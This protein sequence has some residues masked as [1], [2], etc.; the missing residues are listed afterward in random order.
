MKTFTWCF[1]GQEKLSSYGESTGKTIDGKGY[2]KI[3]GVRP[4]TSPY[5]V[6]CHTGKFEAGVHA[7]YTPV[8]RPHMPKLDEFIKEWKAFVNLKVKRNKDGE[9]L[10]CPEEYCGICRIDRE[11][12]FT[13]AKKKSIRLGIFFHSPIVIICNDFSYTDVLGLLEEHTCNLRI[14]NA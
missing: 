14:H 13:E 12:V 3:F 8:I 10:E 9:R 6:R 11:T 4:Y 7:D 1:D 5:T 2:N